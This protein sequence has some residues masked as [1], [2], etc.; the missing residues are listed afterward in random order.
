MA[1]T[2]QFIPV[3]L[4]CWLAFVSFGGGLYEFS[5]VDPFW[6]RRVEIIQPARGGIDRK[7]FWIPVHVAFELALIVGARLHM[8]AT[9]GSFLAA[10]RARQSRGHAHLV[11]LRL[12]PKGARIR[13][14]RRGD[15]IRS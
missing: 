1:L 5:V 13:A 2:A 10:D 12:H 14:R 6:P 7:R 9:G 4:G 8:V 3:G 15:D 11:G